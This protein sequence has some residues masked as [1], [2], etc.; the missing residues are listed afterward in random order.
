VPA[1]HLG[2]LLPRAM[3]NRFD[4]AVF[5]SKPVA[6]PRFQM[7][8]A[9]LAVRGVAL[10]DATMEQSWHS[11]MPEVIAGPVRLGDMQH[12]IKRS[13]LPNLDR[14]GVEI[15]QSDL[16]QSFCL[17]KSL[18]EL[19]EPQPA[20]RRLRK[21]EKPSVLFVP[22]NGVGLGHAKRCSLIADEMRS[23]ST[24]SFAAFPSCIGM[25]TASGFD[26]L[27]LVSRTQHRAGHDN[28][29]MNFARLTSAVRGAAAIVFDGGY[30]FDSVMR[31]AA[32]NDKPS[33]WV[34]RGLWQASQNN[35][36][37]MDRQ[38]TF[39]RIIV[40]TEAFDELNSP[41]KTTE[42]V[43]KVGPIVQRINFEAAEVDGLRATLAEQL[44]LK[45]KKLVVTMLGGGV[46]ADR[47]AQINA[48]CS[49]L[50]GRADG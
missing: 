23:E 26:T 12:W 24:P 36:V 16:A 41:E 28:D 25:L 32:D 27:P 7:L 17:P 29:V 33:I 31:A 34:R 9:N 40:P 30:V 46:A 43:V 14:I 22:T 38:K 2:E 42:N 19:Q 11:Q 5:Y 15:L 48:I 47:R 37:A 50:S 39:T 20:Q 35:Q 44:G 45:G 8:F 49:H 18:S 21:A 13:L 3:A 4:V 10:V 6:W 1:W